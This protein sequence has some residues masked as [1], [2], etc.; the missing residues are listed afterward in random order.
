MPEIHLK[1]PA[2][3][4]Y[5]TC[6]P[7]TKNK[8]GLEKLKKTGDQRYIYQNKLDIACFQHDISYGAFKDL[9]QRIASDKILCDK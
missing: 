4:N 9:P 5:S 6:K 3:F 8:E 1:Q 7:F 2:L